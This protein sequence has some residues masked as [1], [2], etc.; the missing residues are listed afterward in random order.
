MSIDKTY[1]ADLIEDQYNKWRTSPDSVSKEWQFFFEGFELA[2][3]SGV[4]NE[5]HEG[6]A[7]SSKLSNVERLLYRYRERRYCILRNT[8]GQYHKE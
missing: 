4:S 2:R 5:V 6:S 7:E 8:D 3:E 1:S